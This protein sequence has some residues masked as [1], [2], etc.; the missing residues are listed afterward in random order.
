MRL[1][2][3]QIFLLCSL[4]SK[5]IQLKYLR[6]FDYNN[7][8]F[9]FNMN[10]FDWECEITNNT[11]SIEYHCTNCNYRLDSFVST[12]TVHISYDNLYLKE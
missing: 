3:V 9:M 10:G 6:D 11:G 12:E 4:P 1:F 2:I 8:E 5:I 7:Q